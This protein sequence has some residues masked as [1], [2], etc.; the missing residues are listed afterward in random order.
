MAHLVFVIVWDPGK[1]IAKAAVTLFDSHLPDRSPN[2]SK[3]EPTEKYCLIRGWH[4]QNQVRRSNPSEMLLNQTPGNPNAT[5]MVLEAIRD[6][7]CAQ[8][9]NSTL[10]EARWGCRKSCSTP[11]SCSPR[12]LLLPFY[13][14]GLLVC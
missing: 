2:R 1:R 3:Q 9:G 13:L 14:S 11:R 8:Y 7:R 6:L 5:P 10:P 4:Y 12:H